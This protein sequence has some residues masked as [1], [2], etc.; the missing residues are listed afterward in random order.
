MWPFDRMPV[1]IEPLDG[2][3]SGAMR[4]KDP[5]LFDRVRHLP[6]PVAWRQWK[7]T[8]PED[9]PQGGLSPVSAAAIIPK[10]VKLTA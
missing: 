8:Y 9:F 5:E 6:I 10:R 7:E 3:L 1:K 4:A 2:G